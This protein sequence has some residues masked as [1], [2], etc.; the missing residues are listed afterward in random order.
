MDLFLQ[1]VMNGVVIG[2][3]YAVIAVGFAL[4][5]IVLRVVN[6]AHS[7]IFMLGMFAGLGAALHLTSNLAVVLVAGAIGAGLGGM[8]L[9]RVVIR[10]LHGRDVLSTLLAT[11]G[12]SIVLQNGMAIMVGPDPVPYPQIIPNTSMALGPI[13]LTFRQ[14]VNLAACVVLLAAASYYVRGTKYGRATR[15]VAEQPEVAAAFGV[16]VSLIS[17][18]TVVFASLMAGIAAVSVGVLYGS[19]WAFVGLLYGLKAFIILL[20]AGNRHFEGVVLV[21]ISLGIVEALITGYVSSGLRDAV[22]FS[23]LIGVLYFRP[24]GVFGSYNS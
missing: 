16:N 9:E 17:F 24:D 1:Q 3:T 18:I 22:T 20:V 2:S 4:I 11:L 21:A 5:F 13:D 7:E 14:L 8:V 15:A 6:F 23:L 12:V 19:A 10:P